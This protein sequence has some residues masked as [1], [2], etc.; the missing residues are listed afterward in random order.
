MAENRIQ[1]LTFDLDDTLWELAPV[2]R[3]AET[4]SYNWLQSNAPTVTELFTVEQLR[5]LRSQ[6]A[7]DRPDLSH[8]VTELRKLLLR[9][10]MTLAQ[11]EEHRIEAL[12]DA[13]FQVFLQARHE[14][15]LFEAAEAGLDHLRGHFT[16]AAITNGNFDISAVGL[17]RYFSFS[18]NAER[19]Q[20]AKP[21][22][23]PF[24]EALRMAGC[25]ADQCIHIGDDIENDVRGA[26]RVGFATIWLNMRGVAWPGGEPP[27]REIQHLSELPD[28]VWEIAGR[29]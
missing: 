12:S 17:N 14:V 11:I 20:R 16:L 4:L 29:R 3:R 26:Q 28:A 18:V 27:S 6:I 1:L 7:R 9:Q 23:E 13:A 24:E 10:A 21:H 15:E 5:E 19:L 2:L 22:P 25:R 8:R